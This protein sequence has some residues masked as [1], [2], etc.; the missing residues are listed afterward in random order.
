MVLPRGNPLYRG[1]KTKVVRLDSLL[2][3]LE[4][5][6]FSGYIQLEF[7]DA[8]GVIFLE[9]GKV[10]GATCD[11]ETTDPV[12]YLLKR[13]SSDKSGILNVY[14]LPEEMVSLLASVVDAEPRFS[15]FPFDVVKVDRLLERLSEA[16]FTGAVVVEDPE[17]S[18]V[19]MGFFFS[20]DPVEFLYEDPDRSLTGEGAMEEFYALNSSSSALLSV[21]ESS[22]EGTQVREKGSA[23]LTQE[24]VN[25]FNSVL[26][27]FLREVS[28]KD[29][30][31]VALELAEDYPFLDPFDPDV[32]VD[33]DRLVIRDE[34]P[35][36]ELLDGTGE[37]LRRLSSMVSRETRRAAYAA[38]SEAVSNRDVLSPLFKALSGD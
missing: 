25:F 6:S 23:S 7:E 29:I 27:E 36:R 2:E 3:E 13:A 22:F 11:A 5:E 31:K 4:E 8:S 1:M 38:A 10:V 30:K 24:L 37:L 33:G 15:G 34:V 21:V 12:G 16:Q 28:H 18:A 32:Y 17:R 26:P 35:P 9:R 14:S 19:F 20:G